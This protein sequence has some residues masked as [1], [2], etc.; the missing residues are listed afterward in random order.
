MKIGIHAS[1]ELH[2][3]T[4]LL[5]SV[6]QADQQGFRH[7][8]TS[9]HFHPWTSDQGHSGFAWSWLGAALALTNMTYGVVTSPGQRYH[10]AIIAQAAATLDQMFPGRFW[11]AL[12]SG[13]ALNESITGQSWPLKKDRHHRL[14]E[15]A[16]IIRRLWRGEQV[17]HW[18]QVLIEQAQL[19]TRPITRIPIYGAALTQSTATWCGSWADGL[20]TAGTELVGLKKLVEAFQNNGGHGKPIIAQVMFCIAEDEQA[21][22]EITRQQWR[23]A[24]LETK[25]LADLSTPAQ[26]DQASKDIQAADLKGKILWVKDIDELHR[27]LRHAAAI[28]IDEIYLHLLGNQFESLLQHAETLSVVH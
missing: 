15:S 20:I 9:D 17:S 11:L 14:L 13:E 3:P 28:G 27:W 19:F 10:P 7:A 25:Q 5:R 16:D 22:L 6:Q 1:Q 18:G 26:F 12:G 23:V 8:S 4:E 21:A 24:A 2:S